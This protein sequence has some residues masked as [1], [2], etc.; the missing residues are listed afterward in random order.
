M[1]DPKPIREWRDID[2]ARFH[3]EVVPLAQPAVLRGVGNDWPLVRHFRQSEQALVDYLSAFD[4]GELVAATIVPPQAKGRMAYEEG[5]KELNHRNSLERLTNVLKGLLKLM[6]NADPPGV[7]MGGLDARERLPGLEQENR[8]DLVPPGTAAHVWIGNAVTVSPH[9][10]AGDNLA[11]VVA[12]KRRFTLFPPDQVSNLYVG[13]FDLTPA[14]LPISMVAH[15]DPDLERY[16]RF[17][18][19]LD[20]AQVCELGPGD[21]IYIPYLWWHGVESLDPFNMLVNYWWYADEIAAAHP[22]GALLRATY[23]LYRNMPPGHRKAW[24]QMYDHWVFEEHGEP[25]GHLPAAQRTAPAAIDA[26]AVMRFR[27]ALGE[28]LS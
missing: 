10:D 7:F 20:A 13:P 3:S 2:P 1:I 24:K 6:P 8:T 18:E 12:G 28:L 16:P 15:S 27:E 11:V 22:Y 23:E 9:F 25:A 5:A 21:A 14:G 4:S 19:A 26:A 17:R